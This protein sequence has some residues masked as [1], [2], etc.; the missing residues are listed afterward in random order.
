LLTVHRT[1]HIVLTPTSG[2]FGGIEPLA[3]YP[4]RP[5]LP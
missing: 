1:S 5:N 2:T 3:S 4:P